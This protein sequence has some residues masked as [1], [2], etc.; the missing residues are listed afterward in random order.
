[1]NPQT[2]ISC[3]VDRKCVIENIVGYKVGVLVIGEAY[4]W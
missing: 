4:I 3:F 2:P 1:M